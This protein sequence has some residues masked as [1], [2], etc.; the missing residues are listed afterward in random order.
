MSTDVHGEVRISPR[1]FQDAIMKALEDARTITNEALTVAVDK[2]TKQ[3]VSKIKSAAPVKT[4]Q[5]KK[6]WT[7]KV[8]TR[9]GRG[10]YG[11]TVHNWPCYRLTHLLQNGHGGP[12][13]AGPHPHIPSDEETEE[14]FIENLESEMNKQL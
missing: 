12:R 2:T 6:G 3:T 9:K 8:I 13:A 5:Y 10:N 1:D 11:K 7:S 4:G 14:L